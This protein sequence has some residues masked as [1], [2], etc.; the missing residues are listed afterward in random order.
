LLQNSKKDDAPAIVEIKAPEKPAEVFTVDEVVNKF[1]DLK[2]NDKL[3][4]IL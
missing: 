4:Q 3:K 1:A 2:I